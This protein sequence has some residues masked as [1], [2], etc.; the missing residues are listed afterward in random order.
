ML[1]TSARLRMMRMVILM[2][3]MELACLEMSGVQ[4]A[5]TKSL[6]NLFFFFAKRTRN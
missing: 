3:M 6:A 2:L 1:K 4:C 5:G